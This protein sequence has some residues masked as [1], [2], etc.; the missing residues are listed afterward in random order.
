VLNVEPNM[1]LATATYV[2]RDSIYNQHFGTTVINVPRDVK[3]VHIKS[4][5]KNNGYGNVFYK[6]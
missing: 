2:V 5:H 6:R 1:T 3:N 4:T